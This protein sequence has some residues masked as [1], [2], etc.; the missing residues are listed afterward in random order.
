MSVAMRAV[1]IA[2]ARTGEVVEAVYEHPF[3]VRFCHWVNAISL[4]VLVGSGFQI[5][6]AFPS[7]GAKVPQNVLINWPKA[8]ALGGWLGGGLQWH[9]TFM[10]IYIATGAL[11]VGYELVS[12]NYRQILFVPR[13][14]RGVWP[15][16]RHYF[17]FGAKPR[18]TEAYNP[19]QKLAY[20]SAILLGLLSVLTGLAIWKPI[21]FS[22]L[23]WLMGG[24]HLARLG[25]FLVMWAII[26]FVVGH[27]VM[28][29]L[30]GWNN[31]VSIL[32]GWKRSPEYTER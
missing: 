9:L 24:F 27:L 20:M 21:Q 18:G 28:V 11:Y 23:A 30:H 8:Y 26:A 7:F 22:W 16:V 13:D 10:W 1:T 25:H 17:F 14:I 29:I 12:G 6:R 19:L 5:F 2:N 4:F 3:V 31:F 32:T 15:V